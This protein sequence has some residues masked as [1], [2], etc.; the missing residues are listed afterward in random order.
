MIL[1]EISIEQNDIVNQI[2]LNNNVVV[3]SVLGG[4]L[5]NKDNN[6]LISKGKTVMV[7]K[8]GGAL[9]G[10]SGGALRGMAELKV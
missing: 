5:S 9:K 7:K 2:S 6:L 4:S 1:P 3:D 10:L 8:Y